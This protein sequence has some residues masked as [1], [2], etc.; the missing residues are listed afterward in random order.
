MFRSRVNW[1]LRLKQFKPI[2]TRRPFCSR[3]TNSNK[4]E[5]SLSNYDEAYRQLDKLDFMTAAKILFTGP[6]KEKKFG[7]FI[8]SHHWP[9][10][11]LYL[12]LL[13]LLLV[14]CIDILKITFE[15]VCLFSLIFRIC[16]SLIEL[17]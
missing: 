2:E 3:P 11:L 15:K 4:A 9:L 8:A 14:L 7:Y 6:P 17:L 1:V 16:P 12:L 13:L 5:S 10:T